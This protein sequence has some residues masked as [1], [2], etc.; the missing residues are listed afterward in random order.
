MKLIQKFNIKELMSVEI[1]KVLDGHM[2]S[3]SF[4]IGHPDLALE[5]LNDL[6]CCVNGDNFDC[7]GWEYDYWIYV[8]INKRKYC[9]SGCGYYGGYKFGLEE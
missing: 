5:I 8:H 6:E 7:N 1:K 9:I 2:D 4:D 3:V